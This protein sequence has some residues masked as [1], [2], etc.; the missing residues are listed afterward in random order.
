M[1]T[2]VASKDKEILN[3][4]EHT[5]QSA[6]SSQK[7]QKEFNAKIVGKIALHLGKPGHPV[8]KILESFSAAFTRAY[9]DF[10]DNEETDN[11]QL[12]Q[13]I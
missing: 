13:R 11:R 5:S 12:I 7:A 10:V 6:A 8:A 3:A 1:K 9:S 2:K 4:S